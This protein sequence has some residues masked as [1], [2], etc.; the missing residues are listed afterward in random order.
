MK[1]LN[2]I[3][4][5]LLVLVLIMS[6]PA[7]LVAIFGWEKTSSIDRVVTVCGILVFIFVSIAIIARWNTEDE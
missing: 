5:P 6:S 7:I 4:K 1:F 2:L 3:P